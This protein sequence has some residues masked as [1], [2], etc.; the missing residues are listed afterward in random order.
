MTQKSVLQ[1]IRA[2]LCWVNWHA[3]FRRNAHWDGLNFVSTC[4]VCG[5]RLRR[6]DD[7]RWLKDLIE[8]RERNSGRR[9]G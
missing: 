9:D 2:P 6:R 3:P 8:T 7:G 4:K 1:A 5:K